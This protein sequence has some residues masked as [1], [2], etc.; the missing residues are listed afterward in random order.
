MIYSVQPGQT[1]EEI[2]DQLHI[3]NPGYLKD[4]HNKHCPCLERYSGDLIE[5]SRIFVPSGKQVH[6]INQRIRSNNDSCYGFPEAGRYPF[7]FHSWSGTY[8]ASHTVYFN[9]QDKCVYSYTVCLDFEQEKKGNLYYLCTFSDFLKNGKLADTKVAE[10]SASCIGMI[11][12]VRLIIGPDGELLKT[13]CV[14]EPGSADGKLEA[15]KQHFTDRFSAV[16]ISGFKDIL[17]MPDEISRKFAGTLFCAF[18]FGSFYQ[19]KFGDWTQSPI[20][21]AFYPWFSNAVPI[22]FELQNILCRKEHPEDRL[23]RIRQEGTSC[24]HRSPEELQ[25]GT[26]YDPDVPVSRTSADCTHSAEY[27]FSGEDYALQKIEAAFIHF[28]HGNT[29]K[30]VFVLEKTEGFY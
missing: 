23:I 9:D 21:T 18:A 13:E 29:E 12:P 3:E 17:T 4:F 10:L 6:E 14:R 24:D 28:I 2:S 26:A 7:A 27:V 11:Y 19:V 20:Y 22:R 5:G 1:F 16:Y 8:Q 25:C 30:E 15:L